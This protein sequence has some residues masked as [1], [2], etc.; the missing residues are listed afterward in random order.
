MQPHK[1]KRQTDEESGPTLDGWLRTLRQ[2]YPS[3]ASF[4]ILTGS[5][6]ALLGGLYE[7]VTTWLGVSLTLVVLTC[8][9][10]FFLHRDRR[11]TPRTEPDLVIRI[12]RY[13]L[14]RAREYAANVGPLRRDPL[15]RRFEFI[16]DS[17]IHSADEV[18]GGF[19]KAHWEALGSFV[20]IH[21]D[22]DAQSARVAVEQRISQE[23]TAGVMQW[24]VGPAGAGKTTLMHRLYF[25]LIEARRADPNRPIPLLLEPRHL[26]SVRDSASIRRA[27]SGAELLETLLAIWLNNRG[28]GGGER[29]VEKLLALF[30][31]GGVVLLVDAYDELERL[32]TTVRLAVELERLA[33]DY[34]VRGIIASRPEVA[35]DAHFAR[36][37]AV[38]LPPF[39]TTAEAVRY[40]RDRVP[41]GGAGREAFERFLHEHRNESWLRSP[42]CLGKVAVLAVTEPE[43]IAKILETPGLGELQLLEHLANLAVGRLSRALDREK[44]APAAVR[45]FLE[46]MAVQSARCGVFHVPVAD[47][48]VWSAVRLADEL[49]VDRGGNAGSI[50][51]AHMLDFFLA[52]PIADAVQAGGRLPESLAFKWSWNLVQHVSVLLE[53]LSIGEIATRLSSC[54]RMG[55]PSDGLMFLDNPEVFHGTNLL[56]LAVLSMRARGL[57]LLIDGNQGWS[58]LD[59]LKLSGADLAGVTIRGCS[60]VGADLV[61]ANLRNARLEQCDLSGALLSGAD[62][63]GAHFSG[64]KFSI[65][66]CLEV[67]VRFR[68]LLLEGTELRQCGNV[69][70]DELV[71]LGAV[72]YTTRY[73]GAYATLFSERQA[74]LTGP[75]AAAAVTDY[76]ARIARALDESAREPGPQ[77]LVDLMA[78][79][80]NPETR[81]V[82]MKHSPAGL[83][84]LAVDRN[85][86]QL[87]TVKQD[88]E[89]LGEGRRFMALQREVTGDFELVGALNSVYSDS[90]PAPVRLI[91]AKKALHELSRN[92]QR[93]LL[94]QC[95]LTLPQNGQFILYADA[96]PEMTEAQRLSLEAVRGR[97]VEASVVLDRGTLQEREAVLTGLRRRL[98]E[99][100]SFQAQAPDHGF[101]CNLWVMLK[102]WVNDNRHELEH[103]YFSSAHELEAW[104]CH[105]EGTNLRLVGDRREYAYRLFPMLFNEL[106]LK[107]ALEYVEGQAESGLPADPAV[108][109]DRWT[110][111]ERWR[112][113]EDFTRYHLWNG[114][115][116]TPFGRFA[117]A[118]EDEIDLASVHSA[119]QRLG[120][121]DI[122][123]SFPVSIMTFVK[124]VRAV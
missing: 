49:V 46:R 25:Q 103:R 64:C 67:G 76:C 124:D 42:R 104:L 121:K 72:R 89:R 112:L 34:P 75:G 79:G 101:F 84:V 40:V 117:G 110:P 107:R 10:V 111:D 48:P 8:G 15:V 59:G 31:S 52:Q 96:P 69:T 123:F 17:E 11:R 54:R 19:S 85:T 61:R 57:P 22:G 73:R 99:D 21:V 90:L 106:G 70:V 18:G 33:A 91:V 24:I 12:D 77:A 94:E 7:S 78:G 44:V 86:S 74:V 71:R 93:Q 27:A 37:S 16:A 115:Q 97:L 114:N 20:D 83:H 108:V 105:D 35:E 100:M 30:R 47:Q 120:G 41:D 80:G 62:A 68:N 4:A 50:G 26:E 6:W 45:K 28:L 88:F 87:L 56:Q 51:S 58:Q 32:R 81:E 1:E 43:E 119:L 14:T 5:G 66:A 63:T 38:R 82:V 13:N 55:S 53:G 65:D 39:W 118:E 23:G 3:T 29:A 60:L 109:K 36:W 98:L 95:R 92:E 122:G 9:A 113:L 2:R 102:D 116:P